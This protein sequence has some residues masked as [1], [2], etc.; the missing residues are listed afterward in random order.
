MG[1]LV[2]KVGGSL[3]DLPDLRDRLLAWLSEVGSRPV[4]LV[5]GGGAGADVIRR[6]DAIHR[7]G[8]EPSHWLALHVL[9][10]NARFLATL[11]G[12]PLIADTGEAA[13]SSVAVL[14]AHAFAL[15]DEGRPG[16]IAHCWQVTSDCVAARVAVVAGGELVLLKSIDRP[17]SM[18][19]T[20]AAAAGHVD[21]AFPDL[22][23]RAGLRVSWLNL[24]RVDRSR[25]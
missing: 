16:A 4:I 3:F 20:E 5:P 22:V 8:E 6:L 18:P 10:V 2:V 1:P 24:R 21:E 13:G 12:A 11:I 17:D 7:L 19:W 23:D 25:R 9:A 14:D 15:S